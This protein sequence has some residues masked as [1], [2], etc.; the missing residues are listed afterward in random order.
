MLAA[1][2][3]QRSAASDAPSAPPALVKHVEDEFDMWDL[4]SN[5]LTV[6]PTGT[7]SF[8][9]KTAGGGVIHDV[10]V[11]VR[12][13]S[14]RCNEAELSPDEYSSLCSCG[15]PAVGRRPCV[16]VH[17][18]N[19]F[20][21]RTFKFDLKLRT[22]FDRRLLQS[23]VDSFFLAMKHCSVPSLNPGFRPAAPPVYAPSW[24]R[25]SDAGAER[26]LGG[27]GNVLGPPVQ[28][29]FALGPYSPNPALS[30]IGSPVPVLVSQGSDG[31]P[32]AGARKRRRRDDVHRIPD[33]GER[34]LTD[35]NQRTRAEAHA[36][37]VEG[38]LSRQESSSA[39]P[40]VAAAASPV[41]AAA[42]AA[43][44]VV[45]P[46]PLA[47]AALPVVVATPATATRSAAKANGAG[48][49]VAASPVVAAAASLVV[50]AT[51]ATGQPKVASRSAAKA[52]GAGNAAQRGVDDASLRRLVND[53]LHPRAAGQTDEHS[54][55]LTNWVLAGTDV[56]WITSL[57]HA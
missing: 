21:I 50:A 13:L 53:P 7:H 45:A 46:A 57:L 23:A 51:P 49:A 42:A 31:V 34:V 43:S 1:N 48:N 9:I 52:K 24:I 20:V 39:S 26:V 15:V 11:P 3:A 44:P 17:A 6:T 5:S 28:M 12:L 19:S 8:R 38:V 29:R 27:E 41:V 32:M 10:N 37:A 36:A 2:V 30:H 4:Q 35:L 18:V 40:V 55:W 16:H 33:N 54:A 25:L 47:A 22:M 14:S 56:E